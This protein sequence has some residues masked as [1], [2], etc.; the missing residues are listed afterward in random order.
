L[1]ENTDEPEFKLPTIDWAI[2]GQW[3]KPKKFQHQI[4]RINGF[5]IICDHFWWRVL[6]EQTKRCQEIFL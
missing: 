5:E 6:E 2:N 4:E 3:H 1:V